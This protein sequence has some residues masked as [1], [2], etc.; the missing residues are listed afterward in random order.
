VMWRS[1]ELRRR[2]DRSEVERWKTQWNPFSQCSFPPEDELI[3]NFR[4]HVMDRAK[5][6]SGAD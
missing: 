1:C 5:A 3:E 2:P 4:S 6:I